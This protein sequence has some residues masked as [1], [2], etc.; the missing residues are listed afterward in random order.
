M[1]N[2]GF[3][4]GIQIQ[5]LTLE[6][7]YK[8][9][10]CHVWSLTRYIEFKFSGYSFNKLIST[11]RWRCGDASKARC[12]GLYR[13]SGLT[14]PY[15]TITISIIGS[16]TKFRCKYKWIITDQLTSTLYAN[17]CCP[18]STS[19]AILTCTSD[20]NCANVISDASVSQWVAYLIS[21]TNNSWL[22]FTSRHNV[23]FE[24]FCYDV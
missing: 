10:Y 23:K 2:L 12:I 13:L 11:Q 4:M 6:S 15:R 18:L 9:S 17:S 5:Q 19:A 7:S 14:T 22:K 24:S 8:T 1:R 3:K 20:V 16:V 21:R